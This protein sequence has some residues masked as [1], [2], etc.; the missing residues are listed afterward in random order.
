MSILV[1][2]NLSE[3]QCKEIAEQIDNFMGTQ[4][5]FFT[6]QELSVLSIKS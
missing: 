4:E 5:Q 1:N 3:E 2:K 6:V